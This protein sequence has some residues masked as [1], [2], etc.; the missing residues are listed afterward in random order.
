MAD[1]ML[2][3]IDNPFNYFTEYAKWRT[4][5][6]KYAG[7]NTEAWLDT[8]S[9]SNHYMDSEFEE[10]EIEYAMDEFLSINPFGVHVKMYKSDGDAFVKMCNEAYYSAQKQKSS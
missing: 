10:A 7:Y 3:T 2:T 6:T 1:C 5:D 4:F 8:L 9:Y